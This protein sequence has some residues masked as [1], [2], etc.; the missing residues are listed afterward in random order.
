MVTWVC[1]CLHKLDN[2]AN[3]LWSKKKLLQRVGGQIR[4]F[5]NYY[6]LNVDN[7]QDIALANLKTANLSQHACSSSEQFVG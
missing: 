6:G 4:Q 5:I 1:L 7:S 3:T 2:L